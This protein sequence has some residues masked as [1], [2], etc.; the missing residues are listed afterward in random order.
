MVDTGS[1]RLWVFGSQC[2]GEKCAGHEKF[3][4]K[5]SNTYHEIN[6]DFEIEYGSTVVKGI[7]AQDTIYFSE[8]LK[9][10][11][12]TFGTASSVETTIT[13]DGVLGKNI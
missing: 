11:G 13:I 4:E 10:E 6:K 2:T 5:V 1:D 3:Q 7:T 9:A 8:T 12:Q